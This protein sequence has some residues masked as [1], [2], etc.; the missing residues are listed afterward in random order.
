ML[1]NRNRSQVGI[2]LTDTDVRLTQ[3][4][5]QGGRWRVTASTILPLGGRAIDWDEALSEVHKQPTYCEGKAI[6]AIDYDDVV[7]KIITLE[8]ELNEAEM[9]IYLEKLH[10]SN[11]EIYCDY[12]SLPRQSGSNRWRIFAARHPTVKNLIAVM[13]RNRFPLKAIDINDFALARAV[14][15]CCI[16]SAEHSCFG[17]VV[18]RR[19][20]LRVVLMNN[21]EWHASITVDPNHLPDSLYHSLQHEA[22]IHGQ[23]IPTHLYIANDIENFSQLLSSRKHGIAVTVL[24][25][26]SFDYRLLTS[27]GLALWERP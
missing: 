11:D 10:H 17:V 6:A 20:Y 14:N 3:A 1:F 5:R 21:Q 27:L 25:S 7:D 2:D 9:A 19:H 12:I 13:S 16:G 18:L 23:P 8:T 24:K 22:Q 4:I 15:Y 26:D